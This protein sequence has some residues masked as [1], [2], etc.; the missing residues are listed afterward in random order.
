MSK[1]KRLVLL[2]D[3]SA[4]CLIS[5]VFCCRESQSEPLE[6]SSKGRACGVGPVTKRRWR[7]RGTNPAFTW[8]PLHPLGTQL[9][10]LWE[11]SVLWKP[12]VC[13]GKA[14]GCWWKGEG[15]EGRIPPG[16]LFRGD[17]GVCWLKAAEKAHFCW[18]DKY[19]FILQAVASLWSLL[20]WLRQF[21]ISCVLFSWAVLTT[22]LGHAL[23]KK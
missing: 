17:P 10:G 1:I 7:T 2:W 11:S 22:G 8:L 13:R 15:A 20:P 3:G 19:C 21:L 6:S 14:K 16:L 18:I 4:A 5:L 9:F 12:S 23:K